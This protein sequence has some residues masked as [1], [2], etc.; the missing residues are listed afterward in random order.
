[1]N[2]DYNDERDKA[3][4]YGTTDNMTCSHDHINHSSRQM[5]NT[6]VSLDGTVVP[7][8]FDSRQVK[9]F[10]TDM[11]VGIER[12]KVYALIGREVDVYM[13]TQ[14]HTDLSVIIRREHRRTQG[15]DTTEMPNV[16]ISSDNCVADAVITDREGILIGVRV[17]DCV[18][19]VVF[20]PRRRVI[21]AIHAG[22]RGVAQGILKTVITSLCN[23]FFSRPED[24][25][26]AVGPSIK[27]CCYE[28]GPD[29]RD[30]I[31]R[32]TGAGNYDRLEA[33]RWY[34]DLASAN[35]YQ[36]L[37]VGLCREKIWISPECTFC[38][39]DRY[40]SFRRNKTSTGR[41]GGFIGMI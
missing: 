16:D 2:C 36:A 5:I 15:A 21:A 8:I 6:D 40:H 27:S 35:L 28:V 4:P 25:L 22:W 34:I 12:D 19:I 30:E 24:I 11:T 23:D 31:Q 26:L 13:P 39:P 17:A 7:P 9:A 33:G 32:S 29:V 38:L 3:A 14:K 41:Q 18:P 10:F 1:M 37:S 20:D